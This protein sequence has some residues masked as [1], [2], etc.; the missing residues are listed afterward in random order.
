AEG[1]KARELPVPGS[2]E[3]GRA[4]RQQPELLAAIRGQVGLLARVGRVEAL[5]TVET[6]GPEAVDQGEHFTGLGHIPERMSPH[7]DPAGIV[8]AIDRLD[9]RRRRPRAEGRLAIYQVGLEE[10]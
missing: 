5:D 1:A 2:V 7:R 8:D 10:R 6:N 3:V 4:R 9:H